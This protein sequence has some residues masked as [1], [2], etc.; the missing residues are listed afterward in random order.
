MNNYYDYFIQPHIT[1]Y[2]D[3]IRIV[4][5]TKF[6]QINSVLIMFDSIPASIYVI[7]EILP[8]TCQQFRNAL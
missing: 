4:Y 3:A 5:G 6:L 8:L 7:P 1:Y 2:V